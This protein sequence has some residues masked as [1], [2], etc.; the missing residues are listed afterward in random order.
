[1]LPVLDIKM[2]EDTTRDSYKYFITKGLK[3]IGGRNLFSKGQGRAQFLNLC[4]VISN[5]FDHFQV[6]TMLSS[7]HHPHLV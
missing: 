2:Q 3:K 1:M 7:V 6:M 4:F 5:S